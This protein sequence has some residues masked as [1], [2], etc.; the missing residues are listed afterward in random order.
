MMFM[1]GNSGTNASRI[2]NVAC[3]MSR[4]RR[5]NRF[6]RWIR[7][8]QARNVKPRP[9]RL[10]KLIWLACL[11]YFGIFLMRAGF[12]F[13]SSAMMRG[14]GQADSYSMSAET[15]EVINDGK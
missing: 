4:Y 14:G 12:M 15:S 7:S 6:E 1:Q 8:L 13:C 2:E 11:L 5:L 3:S 9:I 10:T